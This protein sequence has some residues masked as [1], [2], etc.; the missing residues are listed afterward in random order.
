MNIFRPN[1]PIAFLGNF[2]LRNKTNLRSLKEMVKEKPKLEH[3]FN[4]VTKKTIK[5]MKWNN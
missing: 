4:M 1:D 2:M 3:E 5:F